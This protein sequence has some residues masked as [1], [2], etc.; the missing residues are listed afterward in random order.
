MM[1][2][3]EI[4][5]FLKGELHGSPEVVIHNLAKIEEA[6][7]GE[8]T[9]LANTKYWHFLE[10]TSASAVIVDKKPDNINI[11]YI[12][13]KNAYLGFVFLLR[14]FEPFAG[15]GFIGVSNRAFIEKSV[16]L[17]ESVAVAPLAYIGENCI[18][19]ENT[20]IYP[21]VVIMQNSQIGD[22]C[23][24]Y[25]NVSIREHCILGNNVIL[26]NGCVIG[27]DGFGFAPQGHTYEKV[28]QMGNVIIEDNVEIQANTTI[29]RATLGS[30]II[31]KGVKLDNLVQ[32]AHNV[33]IG[34]NTVVASQTGIS[35]S[36]EVGANVTIAGQVGV[37]GHIKIGAKS[38]IAGQSG[39]TKNVPEGEV[40][41]GTPAMPMM[42]K[43]RVDVSLK[44]LPELIK[45]V[46]QLEKE[47]IRLKEKKR[48][49]SGA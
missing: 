32:V 19:G 41:F 10:T 15:Y 25:P 47:V 16:K 18:I 46:H 33:K 40:L 35:G 8:I 39:V 11:P 44:H 48:E 34:E 30:T 38:V 2:L 13:V 20:V 22:N 43:K 24:L 45:K 31:Q 21:G 9:F 49:S 36:T 12:L 26:H 29:D 23:I 1:T 6:E 17:G 42:K 28:P 4:S 27:S 7:E 5:E 3:K 14:K 37:A